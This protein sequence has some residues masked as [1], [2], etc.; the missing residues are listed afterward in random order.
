MARTL[1]AASSTSCWISISAASK[2]ELHGGISTYADGA[3]QEL[4]VAAGTD[5]FGGRGHVEGDLRYFNH[6]PD[7]QQCAPLF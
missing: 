6:E 1:S 3:E 5:L 7:Q 2:Y 4:G